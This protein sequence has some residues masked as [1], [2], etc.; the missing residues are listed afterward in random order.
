ML[1]S[2]VQQSESVIRKHISTLLS[3]Y[4]AKDHYRVLSR[5]ACAMQ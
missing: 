5:L 4:F 2:D 3:D 1:V